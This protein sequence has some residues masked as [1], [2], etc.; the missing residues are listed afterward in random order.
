MKLG[1]RGLFLIVFSI[2]LISSITSHATAQQN[3]NLTAYYINVGQGDSELVQ[4][5]GHNILID[6]GEPYE[7]S[8]V[9]SFLRSHGVTSIDLVVNTH[10]DADHLGGLEDVVNS[11]PVTDIANDGLTDTTVTY[12]NFMSDVTSKNVPDQADYA[13]QTINIDPTVTIN[14]YSPPSTHLGTDTNEN[15]VVLKFTY[16]SESFLFVGDA[17]TA[18][19]NY[20]EGAGDNLRA[21]VLKVGHH[22]SDTSSSQSFLTAV[23]PEIAVIE[24]GLNNEYKLPD[25]DI[26]SRLTSDGAAV[27]RTDQD[28]DIAITTDGKS[29]TVTTHDQLVPTPGPMVA[30]ATATITPI[31][32]T[33]IPM[34]AGTA[35]PQVP[36]VS[37]LPTP[38]PIVSDLSTA[39]PVSSSSDNTVGLIC[40]AGVLLILITVVCL[41]VWSRMKHNKK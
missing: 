24:V 27:Y 29:L 28:G 40:C 31:E 2:F 37:D 35:T 5:H 25:A 41:I 22:G 18:T 8:T 20:M 10:P 39:T 9:V 11:F 19:E 7:G 15:S 13:G 33:T 26:I 38:P 23:H 21:D 6:G 4:F 16:G 34:A 17:T 14:V 36:T 30:T 3:N 1:Y 32:T 12:K